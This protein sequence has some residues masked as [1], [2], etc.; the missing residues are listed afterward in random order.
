MAGIIPNLFLSN[1]AWA[2][3]VG[4]ADPD[5]FKQ[6]AQGQSPRILWLGCSDSRVPESVI[7]ASRPGDIFTHRNIANQ[8]HPDDDNVIS[9]I[10]FAVAALGV[11]H[12][13]VVGHTACGGAM[14][15]L[16]A[17]RGGEL[18]PGPLGRWLTPLANLT[19][20]LD[21]EGLPYPEALTKVVEASVV[22]QV[23]S[24]V[25]TEPVQT[26]WK[27]RDLWVHGLVYELETGHLRDLGITR[28]PRA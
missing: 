3:A 6:S 22:A 5:F 7:T 14:A 26:A 12:I 15:C 20:T 2:A 21:L 25:E 18:P 28:G 11:E 16:D 10:T 24:L 27:K 19:R 9:V 13:L 8:V 4:S 1:A 17:A 23:K